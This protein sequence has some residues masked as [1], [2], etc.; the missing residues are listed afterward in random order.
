MSDVGDGGVGYQKLE[1]ALCVADEC[2]PMVI[3]FLNNSEIKFHLSFV[4]KEYGDYS[5]A[6]KEQ[7]LVK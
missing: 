3:S 2:D 4:R 7:N 5:S 1:V 6:E